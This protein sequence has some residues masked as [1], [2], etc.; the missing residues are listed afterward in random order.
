MPE[1]TATA[2][3]DKL[4][5]L[6]AALA[7]LLAAGFSV[8]QAQVV[9]YTV[10]VIA[11]SDHQAA[12][13]VQADL[14]RSGFPAYV[15]RAASEQG[16]V[17]RVRV[18]AF[19]DRSSVLL[20]VSGMPPVAGVTPVPALVESIP[21]GIMPLAPRILAEVPVAGVDIAVAVLEDGFVMRV[22]SSQAPG[23]ADF[24]LFSGGAVHRYRAWQLGFDSSGELIRVRELLMW[25]ENWANDSAEVRDGFHRSLLALVAERLGVGSEEVAAAEYRPSADE[26]PR[27]LVVE[28]GTTSLLE[29]AELLAIGRQ[30]ESG[31]TGETGETGE[32]GEAGEAGETGSAAAELRGEF[33]EFGTVEF[34]RSAAW[35][36]GEELPELADS[37]TLA[38]LV[39]AAESGEPILGRGWQAVADGAY[40]RLTI[41]DPAAAGAE[42]T[43]GQGTSWRASLGRPL[44]SEGSYL[45]AWLEERLLVYGF[46]LR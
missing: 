19:A 43:T 10:Q 14:L 26:P 22:A 3:L 36:A 35:P 25:P 40:I 28:R 33:G 44:W 31:E 8:A 2:A 29:G 18:G 24:L 32:P 6:A 45:V 4:R 23:Q 34:L 37:S 16:D 39:A 12:L 30:V 5:R 46:V 38:E 13:S 7:V 9:P 42:G 15:T 17:W 21:P 20:Y 27:L 41:T 1:R 11:L